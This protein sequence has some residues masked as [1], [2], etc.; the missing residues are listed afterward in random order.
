MTLKTR[1]MSVTS[2]RDRRD[3]DRAIRLRAEAEDLRH[4][5]GAKLIEAKRIDRRIAG[6]RRQR[7]YRARRQEGQ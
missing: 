1:S 7:R 3:I 5:A 4:A 6:R 2:D